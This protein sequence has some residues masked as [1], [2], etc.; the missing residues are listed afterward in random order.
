[1]DKVAVS[2]ERRAVN[3]VLKMSVS[4]ILMWRN[5]TK[6]GRICKVCDWKGS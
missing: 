5:A 3:S 1:M 6:D 4:M 2:A